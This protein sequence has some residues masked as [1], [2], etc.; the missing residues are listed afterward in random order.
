MTQYHY[1][2][3]HVNQ[4][5]FLGITAIL[6]GFK[7]LQVPGPQCVGGQAQVKIINSL[8]QQSIM[9][10][11]IEGESVINPSRYRNHVILYNFNAY[12]FVVSWVTNVE[13]ARSFHDE[14]RFI[15]GMNVLFKKLRQLKVLNK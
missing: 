11:C 9:Y 1:T 2:Q 13:I 6:T 15:V 14:A 5:T 4:V 10:L 3:S 8:V 7:M 12:P